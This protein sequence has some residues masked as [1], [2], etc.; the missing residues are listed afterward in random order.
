MCSSYIETMDLI[1]ELIHG[2]DSLL[3][4]CECAWWWLFKLIKVGSYSLAWGFINRFLVWNLPVFDSVPN[5]FLL[6]YSILLLFLDLFGRLRGHY[7]LLLHAYRVCWLV[8]Y[9]FFLCWNIFFQIRISD[10]FLFFHLFNTII[11]VL[12]IPCV[13]WATDVDLFAAPGAPIRVVVVLV[14]P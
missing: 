2:L 1:T 14:F 7:K 5:S 9:L 6:D 10:H 8:L 3:G 13:C 11:T 12:S 4:A